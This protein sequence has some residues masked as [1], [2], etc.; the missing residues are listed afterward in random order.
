MKIT[1][2]GLPGTG[3]G[4][5]GKILASKHGLEFLS[6]GDIFRSWA[7]EEGVTLSEF[8]K[9]AVTDSQFDQKLDG[10]V[11]EYGKN[12]DNFIFD[13]RLAWHFI[14]DSIKI[15]LSCDLEP[16]IRRVADRDGTTYDEALQKS[17][18]REQIIKDNY[19]GLYGIEDYIHD[20]HFD[21]II[22]TTHLTVE[23]EIEEIE[24]Y[25][26]SLGLLPL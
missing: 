14:P 20:E 7:K 2:C 15:K 5:L 3:K 19:K 18:E 4:T 10:R 21:L 23:Q 8:E 22:D 11:G 16:R 6:A 25:L 24:K 9:K 1:F 13:G 12:N 17:L 26:L